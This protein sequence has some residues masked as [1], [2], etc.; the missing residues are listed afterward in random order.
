MYFKVICCFQAFQMGCFIAARFLLTSVTSICN[1]RAYC[2]VFK[3][4]FVIMLTVELLM[5]NNV[6]I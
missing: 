1:N 4:I 5:H 3:F 6:D 2:V